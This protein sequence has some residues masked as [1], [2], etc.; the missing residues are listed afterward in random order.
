MIQA[1]AAANRVLNE[2]IERI[3]AQYQPRR[4]YLF[5]SRARGDARPDSDYDIL[6]EVDGKTGDR[7]E[8]RDRISVICDLPET[9]VQVHVRYP[10]QLERRKDD[11][12][13][14]DWDVVREGILLF[15]LDGL[16]VLGPSLGQRMVREPS[17]EVPDSLE[18]WIAHAERD[19]RLAV[20]L[21]ADFNEWKESICFHSQQAG[22]KFLKALIIARHARPARTH[23]L[24]QLVRHL[25][26]LGIDLEDLEAESRFLSRFA[27]EV[28]Y[29]DEDEKRRRLARGDTFWMAEP[30]E[31]TEAE[32][33]RAFNAAQRI[34]SAVRPH[35][36]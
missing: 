34:E 1:P 33:R 7:R 2:I 16:S 19:M 17:R 8:D 4:I 32:A 30:F 11:P 20:H 36:P 31:V 29:P 23:K 25:R 27:V 24:A 35:L 26:K 14:V 10:G 22:E 13:T 18:G 9:E 3:V 12:G 21:S 28:R 15:T 6:V 5:G